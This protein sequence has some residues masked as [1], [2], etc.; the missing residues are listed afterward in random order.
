MSREY[1]TTSFTMKDGEPI[2]CLMVCPSTIL[3][4]L[5]Q[6]QSLAGSATGGTTQFYISKNIRLVSYVTVQCSRKYNIPFQWP[7]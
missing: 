1:L 6:F 3:A 2:L 4:S 5:G 7:R